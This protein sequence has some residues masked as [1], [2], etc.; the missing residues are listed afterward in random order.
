MSKIENPST[1]KTGGAKGEIHVTSDGAI[2]VE[3]LAPTVVLHT[4]NGVGNMDFYRP[5]VESCDEVLAEHGKLVVLI[6]SWDQVRME[7][8]FREALTKYLQDKKDHDCS[9]LML[10]Q[11]KL[12][13][14]AMSVMNM[15]TGRS[16]FETFANIEQWESRCGEHVRGMRRRPLVR[17]DGGYV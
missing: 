6:D 8:D 15:L 11:S 5:I 2:R 16:Y 12:I 4:V 3:R 7:T 10:V 13:Q 14:M 9:A 1:R 17:V